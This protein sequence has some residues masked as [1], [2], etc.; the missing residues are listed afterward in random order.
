MAHIKIKSSVAGEISSKLLEI[1]AIKLNASNPFTWSSGIKSPIYCDNRLA[2]SY[3]AVRTFVKNE[4][5][6]TIKENFSD[7]QGIAGVATAGIPQGALIAD[8]LGLPFIYIRS[9]PKNHGMT[10]LIEGKITPSLKIVVVEDLVSTGG[11]SLKAVEAIR[12]SKMEVLGMV[13]I[14]NYGFE[15]AENNFNQSRVTLFCLSDYDHLLQEAI[16]SDYIREEDLN[17]LRS[18][19]KAPEQWYE[20]KKSK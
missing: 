10:N 12:K 8:A 16:K 3:P 4:L 17:D 15:V 11:S 13:A 1:G 20:V 6:Q 2:L 14:F 9:S 18:W 19:R 5:V 7:V